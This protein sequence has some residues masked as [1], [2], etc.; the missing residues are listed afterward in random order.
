MIWGT[1]VPENT[2]LEDFFAG[3][4]GAP[5]RMRRAL[6]A[7]MEWRHALGVTKGWLRGGNGGFFAVFQLA[8]WRFN[9]EKP[10]LE[11]ANKLD[12]TGFDWTHGIELALK[13]CLNAF[14]YS[15][16]SDPSDTNLDPG[17]HEFHRLIFLLFQMRKWDELRHTE[18][19]TCKG[20]FEPTKISTL[21]H[22]PSTE[23][24]NSYKIYTQ[25]FFSCVFCFFT[26]FQNLL[27][28]FPNFPE[29]KKPCGR[30]S[31]G[32][33]GCPA[34]SSCRPRRRWMGNI[35]QP[36]V[37]LLVA[38]KHGDFDPVSNNTYKVVSWVTE[39]PPV[40]HL[41]M[42]FS[43]TNHFCIPHSRRKPPQ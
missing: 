9:E 43:T 13:W 32:S 31:F 17:S 1:P 30:D 42:G 29:G 15:R 22:S 11:L 10:A 24:T 2:C 21:S 5:R 16:D 39:V 35:L 7:S 28:S 37:V 12:L 41:K 34:G 38:M 20:V 25:D 19:C 4:C 18:K 3:N 40:I 23:W 26:I 27:V 8:N 6:L 14:N 33:G 36:L